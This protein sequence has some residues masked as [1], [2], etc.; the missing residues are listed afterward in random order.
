ML[1][2]TRA[3]RIMA[4]SGFAFAKWTGSRAAE[5]WDDSGR[6]V[7]Q[8]LVHAS[9]VLS[10]RDRKNSPRQ[11]LSID[12]RP[13]VL[14]LLEGLQRAGVVRTVVALGE[15]AARI[16]QC[17]NN[18]GLSMMINYVHV[19]PSLWR[20][21][22]NSLLM[23]RV[24]FPTAEPL[25]IVRADQLYDWRLLRKMVTC[26]FTRGIDAFALIDTAAGTLDWA[27]GA[28]CSRTCKNGTCNALAKVQRVEGSNMASAC[29]HR[30]ERYDAVIAGDVYAARPKIFEVLA[31]LSSKSIYCTTSEAMMELAAQGTLACVEVGDLGCHWFGTKTIAAMFRS[32][33]AKAAAATKEVAAAAETATATAAAAAAAVASPATV[34]SKS[35]V[36]SP[37]GAPT[38]WRH[39]VAAARELLDS[40]Q[41]A[42]PKQSPTGPTGRRNSELL[43]LLTLGCKLGEGANCEVLSAE[44]GQVDDSPAMGW[45]SGKDVPSRLAVKVYHTG[46]TSD[47]G[48]G[49]TMRE[50]MWEVHVLRQI[51]HDHIVRLCDI[52]EF[53]DSV[54]VV[55]EQYEGPDLQQ[56]IAAQPRGLLAED[57]ARRFFCHIL[58]ALRHAHTRGYLHCDLKPGN[59]RLSRACDR[60]I[61]VDWGM[62]R[63]IGTQPACIT[64]GSPSYASPEQLTGYHPEQ[65]WGESAKLCAGADVWSLGVTLYEMLAGRPPFCGAD[66]QEL[67]GNVMKLRYAP[68]EESSTDTRNIIA[69]MLQLRPS[70][71][72]TVDELCAEPWV[73]SCG[74]LPAAIELPASIG[75]TRYT[76]ASVL[77][78]RGVHLGGEAGRMAQV[79]ELVSELVAR[80]QRP[81]MAL[82]YVGMA[83]SALLWHKVAE[84]GVPSSQRW[85]PADDL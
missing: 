28:H 70:E 80:W 63:A 53:V 44:V 2:W 82:L 84:D 1:D 41:L 6:P 36:A 25:L 9:A 27:N 5:E 45:P 61:L 8:A 77:R 23:A 49:A 60:A 75:L 38:A 22:A 73:V 69:S 54:Y 19:P 33:A 58:S 21:L 26:S 83:G 50:V 16:E 74:D 85:L 72:A 56:H 32:E 40:S 10:T 59:V 55:M 47:R 64:M 57:E 30:I 17:I 24:A 71:R 7:T 76:Q 29:G 39:V 67:V 37:R 35:T 31:Q 81:L 66:M 14:H 79:V 4:A 42:S 48:E 46:H 13:L 20:N 68:P 18:A 34:V 78:S 12:M 11:V 43:P 3:F 52:I 15:N 62:A 51:R 65:A